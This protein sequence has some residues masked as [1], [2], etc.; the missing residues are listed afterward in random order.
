MSGPLSLFLFLSFSLSLFLSLS[1][2]PSPLLSLSLF[3]SL[4]VC[5]AVCVSVCGVCLRAIAYVRAC[6]CEAADSADS[7]VRGSNH[8]Q[9]YRQFESHLAVTPLR[10]QADSDGGLGRRTRTAD[11]EGHFGRPTRTVQVREH[12]TPLHRSDS[13]PSRGG[14]HLSRSRGNGT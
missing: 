7:G 8:A 1:L 3:F 12:I 14:V 9:R 13:P 11:L 6:L 2:P 4:F 10:P 5:F